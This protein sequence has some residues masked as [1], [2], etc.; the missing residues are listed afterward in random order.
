M[1]TNTEKNLIFKVLL[2]IYKENNRKYQKFVAKTPI[3]TCP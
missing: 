3:N 1:S 2:E